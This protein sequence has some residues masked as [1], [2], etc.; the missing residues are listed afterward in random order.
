MGIV[1]KTGDNGTTGL[2]Y[3]RRVSK[4]H[5]RVEAYGCVDEL[6]SALGLARATAGHDLV[7]DNLLRILGTHGD[8][9][10]AILTIKVFGQPIELVKEQPGTIDLGPY[11][12][13]A[14]EG[15]R[16]YDTDHVREWWR[17][18]KEE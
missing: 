5:P 15:A 12:A 14:L 2:M 10:R 11:F 8:G 6:N 16:T 3:N 18:R 13:R 17:S 4:C 9:G 7:R 1:T